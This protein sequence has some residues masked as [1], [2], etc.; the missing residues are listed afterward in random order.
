MNRADLALLLV[1]AI[2]GT[3]FALLRDSVRLLHPVDLMAIRFTIGGALLVAIYGKRIWPLERRALID[4]AWLGLWLGAGYLTQVIG[5]ATI[6]ASRSAFIT[7][8]YVAVVP[9]VAFLLWRTRP[10]IAELLGVLL[11]M[12]G[13]FAFSADAGF[14]LTPGDLWTLGCAV[15]F[16]VQ[17]II[18]NIVVKRSDPMALSV[19]QIATCAAMGWILVGAR[20]GI[21]TP[22]AEIPWGTLLYL[23]VFATALVIALQTWA[24]GRTSPVKASIF[25]SLE[26]VFAAI[27][28]GLVFGERMTPRELTGAALILAGVAASE[29]WGQ[30]SQWIGSKRAAG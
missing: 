20:G 4:G 22:A 8:S 27:F 16:G 5:L 14:S 13:L 18:T 7:G 17:I 26:P 29:L 9:L 30:V 21:G 11:I 2:W 23:A 24:L 12:A 1:A 25:F 19:V 6:T 3:T 15:I 10:K 28:A